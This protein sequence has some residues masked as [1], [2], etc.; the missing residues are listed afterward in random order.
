MPYFV[1]G[2]KQRKGVAILFNPRLIV[3]VENQICY[4]D[5]IIFICSQ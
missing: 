1:D 5:G 4:E 2:R 3:L